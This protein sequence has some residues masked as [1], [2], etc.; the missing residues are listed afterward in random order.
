[1]M[2]MS[3]SFNYNVS[4]HWVRFCRLTTIVEMK[5]HKLVWYRTFFLHICWF[6]S[7]LSNKVPDPNSLCGSCWPLQPKQLWHLLCNR[8]TSSSHWQHLSHQIACTPSACSQTVNRNKNT[9]GVMWLPPFLWLSLT[10][11]TSQRQKTRFTELTPP[12][13]TVTAQ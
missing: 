11:V 6:N 1:M 8:V 9:R 2:C 10:C 3:Y 12:M 7:L 4:G 13:L 5:G